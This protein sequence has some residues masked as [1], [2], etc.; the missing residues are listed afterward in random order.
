MTLWRVRAT[1]DDRP[2]FLAVLT[3]GR[4]VR[5]AVFE[6]DSGTLDSGPLD[7][8]MASGMATATIPSAGSHRMCDV[9]SH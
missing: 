2:G 6:L 9:R 3:A 7:S 5:D 4:S 8:G 1:V